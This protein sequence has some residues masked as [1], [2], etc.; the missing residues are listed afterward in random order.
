[1]YEGNVIECVPMHRTI[2]LCDGKVLEKDP[3]LNF[4]GSLWAEGMGAQMR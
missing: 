4:K 3:G 1:M 2:W